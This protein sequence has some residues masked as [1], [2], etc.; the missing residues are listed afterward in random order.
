MNKKLFALAVAFFSACSTGCMYSLDQWE[1]EG[2]VIF[3]SD[4]GGIDYISA[5]GPVCNNGTQYGFGDVREFMQ[6]YKAKRQLNETANV[7]D[8]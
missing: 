8:K 1:A 3:C 2:S 4:K 7:D 5:D 6:G